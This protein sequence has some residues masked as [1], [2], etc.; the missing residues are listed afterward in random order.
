MDSSFCF[1]T[2]HLGWSILHTEGSLVIISTLNIFLLLKIVF[3][4]TNCVDPDEIS[5]GS[6]LFAKEPEPLV[7]NVLIKVY[8]CNICIEKD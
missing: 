4:I 5:S 7:Y 1:D 3:V 6:S 2:I 8:S